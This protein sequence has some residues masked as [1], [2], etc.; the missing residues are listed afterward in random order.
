VSFDRQAYMQAYCAEYHKKN[1]DKKIAAAKAWV[2]KNGDRRAAWLKAYKEKNAERLRSEGR[3]KYRANPERAKR[4]AAAYRRANPEKLRVFGADR[5]A[6]EKASGGKLSRD[7]VRRL[8]WLQ[9]GMCPACG[10]DLREVGHHIDHIVPL[11]AGGAH[12]D[13]NVQLLC[14][15]CNLSKQARDPVE[16]MQSKGFLL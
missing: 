12:E 4:S 3:E 10:A 11:K 5:R 2:E 6:R 1:R 15:P 8:M 13:A 14:P 16:F 7:I 9:C